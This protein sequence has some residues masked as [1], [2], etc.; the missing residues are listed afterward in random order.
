LAQLSAHDIQVITEG[1]YDIQVIT[2]MSVL[3]CEL[4]FGGFI[5]VLRSY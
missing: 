2:E 4:K 3:E 1:A 5:A